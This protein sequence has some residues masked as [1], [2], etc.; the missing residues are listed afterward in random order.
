MVNTWEWN[1]R[2]DEQNTTKG[3]F[4]KISIRKLVPAAFLFVSMAGL[5]FATPQ[6]QGAKQDMKDA[7]HATKEAAEDTGHATKKVA[8]KTGHAV[9][10]TT[11]KAAHKVKHGA[12][13]VHDKVDPN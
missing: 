6:D 2:S 10:R 4:M 5:A 3:E 13:K 12:E 9:K 8:K 1:Q 7:G 11:K